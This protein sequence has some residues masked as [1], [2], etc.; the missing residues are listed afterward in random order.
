MMNNCLPMLY[1]LYTY[2]GDTHVKKVFPSISNI[3]MC[4]NQSKPKMPV[5]M[6][7]RQ[8]LLEGGIYTL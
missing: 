5:V 3:H 1:I 6:D 8:A 7:I 2:I 4:G